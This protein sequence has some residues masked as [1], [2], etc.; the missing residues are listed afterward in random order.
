MEVE[1]KDERVKAGKLSGGSL[2]R[3]IQKSIRDLHGIHGV[4][5]SKSGLHGKK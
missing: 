1:F 5:L 3:A 2:I 4:G